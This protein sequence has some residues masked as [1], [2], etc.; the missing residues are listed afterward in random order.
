MKLSSSSTGSDMKITRC[1]GEV[2]RSITWIYVSL[3][4][5]GE[6]VFVRKQEKKKG[7]ECK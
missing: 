2:L 7:K 1:K 5:G 4:Y 6:L 3:L